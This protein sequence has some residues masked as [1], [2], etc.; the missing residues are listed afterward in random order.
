MRSEGV[1]TVGNTDGHFKWL[2]LWDIITDTAGITNGGS[3]GIANVSN[4]KYFNYYQTAV[5]QLVTLPGITN[6][7]CDG[8]I[9]TDP[10][11][12]TSSTSE[13]L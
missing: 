2:H 4:T 7:E 11:G 13:L 5:L 1:I 12:S 6:V 8:Y 9:I 3:G 10:D